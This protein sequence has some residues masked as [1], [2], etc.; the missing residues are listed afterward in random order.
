MAGQPGVDEKWG[1]GIQWVGTALL[2]AVFAVER[3][4]KAFKIVREKALPQTLIRQ[5]ELDFIIEDI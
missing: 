4:P 3:F 1:R 5:W 2:F